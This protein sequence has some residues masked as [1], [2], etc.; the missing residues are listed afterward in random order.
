M[1][2]QT[3][4]T[5]NRT[6]IKLSFI[7][8]FFSL[9]CC[10]TTVTAQ[11]QCWTSVGSDGTVDEADLGVVALS[12]NT[13]AVKP[14]TIAATVEIRYNIVATQGLF[15]GECNTKTLLI[16]YADNGSQAQVIVRVHTFNIRTGVSSILAEFNSNNHATSNVAQA[17]SVSFATNFF[18]QT[19][20]YY[21]EVI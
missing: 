15:G 21:V 14:A 5:I 11:Q 19:N 10:F 17:R 2:N 9:F 1:E 6:A 18:F 16:R 3:L 4:I 20:I 8:L 7:G 13:A 12:S